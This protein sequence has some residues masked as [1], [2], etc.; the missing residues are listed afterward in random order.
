MRRAALLVPMVLL[1]WS[2]E[3]RAPTV[4][5]GSSRDVFE[6][7]SAEARQEIADADRLI[8]DRAMR[9]IGGRRHSRR[10]PDALARVTF[11]GMTG[12]QVV[13]DQKARETGRR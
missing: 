7:T 3:E 10:D 12:A 8:F 13:D 5:D 6:R 9:T 11:D 4:I 2:C 1:L